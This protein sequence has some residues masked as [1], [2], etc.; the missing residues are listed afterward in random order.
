M[1]LDIWGNISLKK[2]QYLAD[3]NQQKAK[4]ENGTTMYQTTKQKN[5]S[6]RH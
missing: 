5:D 1:A 6:T 2:D 4:K 3:K